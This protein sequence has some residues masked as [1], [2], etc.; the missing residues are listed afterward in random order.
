[1]KI[2]KG[3]LMIMGAALFVLIIALVIFI[4]NGGDDNER[5]DDR[6]SNIYLSNGKV[7][8]IS[9]N[10]DAHGYYTSTGRIKVTFSRLAGVSGELTIRGGDM[11]KTVTLEGSNASYSFAGLDSEAAY[12]FEWDGVHSC[13][14]II[15]E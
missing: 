14:V 15:S 8:T 5:T 10:I 9:E 3:K 2:G 6:I 12:I 1:M 7:D 13:D 4:P 11:E